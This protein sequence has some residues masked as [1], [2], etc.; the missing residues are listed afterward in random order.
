MLHL[1]EWFSMHKLGRYNLTEV[2]FARLFQALKV[3]LQEVPHALAWKFHPYAG[4]NKMRI[5]QL[6][7]CCRNQRC[8][9]VA[10]G[11]S[12]SKTDL[13]KLANELTF[14]LNRIYLHFE[15][16]TFRPT[17]YLAVNELVLE[18]FADEIGR[19]EMPKFLNWN[20]RTRYDTQDD[21]T[22]FLK[23]KMVLKDSFQYDL[24]RPLVV[25]GTVTFVALQLA[26]YM[27]FAKVI[28]IG[29]DHSYGEKGLPSGTE[30]RA[31][32][33]DESHFHPQYFPKG[34]K[35]QLPDLLRSEV[36][37]EIA[38]RAFEQDGREILD[39]T[40]G[41]KCPVFKKVDYSTLF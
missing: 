16:S 25:G 28:L 32:E 34:V 23:S 9:I 4:V 7:D 37:F 1:R 41:G 29:L 10:N 35:W 18:Q 31:A 21:N 8:F 19:L 11:P 13:G 38:R 20:R 27:G 5:R 22:Y 39:A 3:R 24:T 40:I 6:R 36:D 14:G 33:R 17:Y 26:Y 30:I 12:L 2:S 15:S